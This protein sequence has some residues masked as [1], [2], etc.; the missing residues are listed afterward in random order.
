MRRLGARAELREAPRTFD[1]KPARRAAVAVI[2]AAIEWMTPA[3]ASAQ[4]DQLLRNVLQ[5]AIQVPQPARPYYPGD[6][7]QPGAASAIPDRRMVAELQRML[8]DLGYNAGT[9]DGAFGSQTVQALSSFERDHGQP[10]SGGL[11]P[12]ALAALRSV[13]YERNRAA[14]PG[15]AG[16]DQAIARPSFDCAR[17]TAPSAR[18]ICGS[19]PLAQLDAEMAA[20]YIAAK[21][22]LPTDQQ[23]KVAAEQHEWLRRRNG[24]GADASCLERAL[25]ERLSQLQASATTAGATGIGAAPAVQDTPAALAASNSA[26]ATVAAD[27]TRDAAAAIERLSQPQ[28]GLRALKFPMLE[29]RPVFV[30]DVNGGGN[31]AAFF[32]LVALGAGPNLIEGDDGEDNARQFANDFLTRPNKYLGQFGEWAGENEFQRAASRQAFLS[33]HAE[34][35]RQMAPKTPFEFVFA[36]ELIIGPYDA[37]LGGFP[38]KGEPNLRSLPYGSLQPSPDF[39][40]PELLLPIDK[41]GAR[42]LLDRLA[43]ARTSNFDNPRTVRLAAVIE[44]G[45]SNPGSV[46]LQLGLRRLTLY[47]DHLTQ[48]L[49]EFPAPA[50]SARPAQ[51]VVSRLLAPPPGVMPIRL[52]T[53]EGRPLLAADEA[54]ENFLGLVALGQFPDL[55]RERQGIDIG[56]IGRL[57]MLLV[58]TLS[59]A[60]FE[61]PAH[62][63]HADA[64]SGPRQH[65]EHWR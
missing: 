51:N 44:A 57:E 15:P 13:W 6:S 45:R 34:Q 20:A 55:L 52:P 8:D 65:C 24:C 25:A 64:T 30:P 48:S 61:F 26:P 50:A 33:D 46:D 58:R 56:A 16:V 36:T 35:L 7:A 47:D 28:A 53:I 31:E 21:A 39:K 38:L 32:R 4:L 18:T 49:Y 22:G 17:A 9:A 1:F 10:S 23:A 42:R 59:H 63:A 27:E 54:S 62:V 14:A 3:G 43:A 40:W 2:L 12:A 29:G 5:N 41:E 11:S 37:K 60:G 19:A